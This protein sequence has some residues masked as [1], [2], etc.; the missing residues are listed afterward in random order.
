MARALLDKSSPEGSDASGG[1]MRWPTVFM[2]RS[3]IVPHRFSS[4]DRAVDSGCTASRS[5]IALRIAE[6]LLSAGL[7]FGD[8]VR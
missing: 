8:S 5:P 3:V 1:S 2:A 4:H 7:P 6:R